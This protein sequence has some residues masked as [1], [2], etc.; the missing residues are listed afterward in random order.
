MCRLEETVY[1]FP[2]K[3]TVSRACFYVVVLIMK[4]RPPFVHRGLKNRQNNKV[5]W[6]KFIPSILVPIQNLGVIL[7]AL[8]FKSTYMQF[9]L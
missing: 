6:S 1:I 9:Y 2:A 7:V 5:P 8:P 3:V 4:T